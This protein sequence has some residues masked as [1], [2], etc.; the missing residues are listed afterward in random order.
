MFE[1][2]A[3][4]MYARTTPVRHVLTDTFEN[5]GRLRIVA[6]AMDIRNRFMAVVAEW[7]RYRIMAYLVTSSSPV[8]LKTRRVG[9]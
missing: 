7:Y 8:P 6:A 1:V 5:N 3:I 2:A 4:G 9:K